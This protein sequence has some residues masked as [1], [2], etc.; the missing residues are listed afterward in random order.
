MERI[1]EMNSFR[2]KSIAPLLALT[3]MLSAC[4]IGANKEANDYAAEACKNGKGIQGMVTW[5]KASQLDSRWER[6]ANA[7]A[8]SQVFKAEL[9]R[10]S[11][12]LEKD[13]V[14]YREVELSWSRASFI[15]ISECAALKMK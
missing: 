11:Q 12:Y 7:H 2:F 10:L 1:S 4:T 15:L 5:S 6:A 3:M 14:L 13:D 8:D 9:D